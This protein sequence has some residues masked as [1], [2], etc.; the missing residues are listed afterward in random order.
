MYW[1]CRTQNFHACP[2]FYSQKNFSLAVAHGKRIY[3]FRYF[4][5]SM[6]SNNWALKIPPLYCS[7][8]QS[9]EIYGH[10]RENNLAYYR[11]ASSSCG[12]C[13]VQCYGIRGQ[14][15]AFSG[16]IW[17]SFRRCRAHAVWHGW[18]GSFRLRF[19]PVEHQPGEF[20]YYSSG[21]SN[22]LTKQIRRLFEN[23]RSYHRFPKSP[24]RTV[25]HA[26]HSLRNRHIR[27]LRRLVLCICDSSWLARFGLLYLQD[28]DWAGQRLLP[29][30]WVKYTTTDPCWQYCLN[31]AFHSLMP[32]TRSMWRLQVQWVYPSRHRT[33]QMFNA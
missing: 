29:E 6:N 3:S 17:Q 2:W 16:R 10:N 33:E 4:N 1:S 27:Y 24:V 18:Y 26:Q 22:L 19:Q 20:F 12:I 8:Y 32:T 30:V 28:G 11:N 21:T 13:F 9:V 5:Q 23:D 25:R 7:R 14:W 15:F 31:R